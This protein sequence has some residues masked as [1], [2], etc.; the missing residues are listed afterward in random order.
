MNEVIPPPHENIPPL[1]PKELVFA[2]LTYFLILQDDSPQP[3]SS[4]LPYLH[5]YT[6]L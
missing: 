4:L 2:P 6:V 1:P 3:E 5:V